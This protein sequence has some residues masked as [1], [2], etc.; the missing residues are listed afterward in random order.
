MADGTQNDP[1][2][3]NTYDEL[4]QY[5]NNESETWVKVG[6]D[7]DIADEYP[8]G[9]MPAL[10]IKNTWLDGNNKKVSNWYKTNGTI[11]Q[12]YSSTTVSNL[13]IANIYCV[14][15]VAIKINNATPDNYHFA[16]CK[17]SGLVPNNFTYSMDDWHAK[18]HYARCSF[19]LKGSCFAEG[20][21]TTLYIKDCYIKWTGSGQVFGGLDPDRKVDSCYIEANVPLGL[22]SDV[23]NSVAD[24]TSDGVVAFNGSSGGAKN[25]FNKTHCPNGTAGTGWIE[26]EDEH[27]LDTDW[28]AGQGFNAG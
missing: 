13:F 14:G 17:F 6:S 1:Y 20:M 27:W 24:I 5:C 25:I 21:Y 12:K 22:Y 3:A 8:N 9:D 23:V 26:V 15:S 28:L 10:V 11:I 7:I 4:V 16:D 18:N 2:I 19:N